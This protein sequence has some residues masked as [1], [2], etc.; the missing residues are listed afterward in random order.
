MSICSL[1]AVFRL[2]MSCCVPE[3]FAIK[4]RSCPKLWRNFDVFWATKFQAGEGKPK[5]LTEFD[6]SGSP[7]NMWQ[8]LVT[9]GQA[10]SEIRRWKK[11]EIIY[12]GKTEWAAASNSWRPDTGLK[13]RTSRHDLQSVQSAAGKL[14]CNV[15]LPELATRSVIRSATFFL[16]NIWLQNGSQIMEF[17]HNKTATKCITTFSDA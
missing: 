17:G 15:Q 10:T 16:L 8:S 3:I 14:L 7:S 12:S 2:T 5:F 4:S 1:K 11:E 6:Q 9:I 13:K